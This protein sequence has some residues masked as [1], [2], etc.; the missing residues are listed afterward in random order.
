[1]RTEFDEKGIVATYPLGKIWFIREMNMFNFNYKCMEKKL[2]SPH[3]RG[4]KT[5][6]RVKH[7]MYV[8]LV[9]F[10]SLFSNYLYIE[11]TDSFSLYLAKSLSF[12]P[13]LYFMLPLVHIQ[14]WFLLFFFLLLLRS[15]SSSYFD[16]LHNKSVPGNVPVPLPVRYYLYQTV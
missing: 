3:I 6:N 4:R 15:L 14:I 10:L 5:S 12:L 7:A 8:H 16:I 13:Y 2:I 11:E 1:M 9:L